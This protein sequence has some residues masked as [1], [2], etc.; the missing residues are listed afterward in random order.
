MSKYDKIKLVHILTVPQS[1]RFLEGQINYFQKN[2]YDIHIITSPG[3]LLDEFADEQHI[4]SYGIEMPRKITPF[5]DLI[6]IWNI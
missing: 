6:A 1:L 3:T 5:S 4:Q 2:D